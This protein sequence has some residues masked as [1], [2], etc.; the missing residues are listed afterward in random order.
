MQIGFHPCNMYRDGGFA[1]SRSCKSLMHYLKERKKELFSK[2][3][4]VTFFYTS[5]LYSDRRESLFTRPSRSG[6]GGPEKDRPLPLSFFSFLS[7][8][9]KKKQVLGRTNRLLFFI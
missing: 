3:K 9:R 1:L 2:D 5:L 8:F 6:L 4:L 7:L